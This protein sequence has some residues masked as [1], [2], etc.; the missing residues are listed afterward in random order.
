MA[1]SFLS[2]FRVKP[3][4]RDRFVELIGAMEANA[5]DEPDTLAYKFYR[6]GEE[7]MFA[8]YESFT[9]EN[10]DKKH[11][12]NPANTAIIA[13]MIGCMAGGYERELLH[14]VTPAK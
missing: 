12:A 10:G 5:V 8:V 4:T 6:L 9:D 7:N 1:Y 13:E 14:D 3:E 11:Q 2:R